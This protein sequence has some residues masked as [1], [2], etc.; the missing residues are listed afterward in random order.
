MCSTFRALK[1][2]E[3]QA[4]LD[5]LEQREYEAGAVIF[6]QGEP[7]DRF[8]L[9]RSGRARVVQD[10]RELG[11]VEVVEEPRAQRLGGDEVELGV[12]PHQAASLLGDRVAV[13]VAE[14][15]EHL[16]DPV[17][18]A[19]DGVGASFDAAGER[20]RLRV[21]C[22]EQVVGE[23][24]GGLRTD[25]GQA[26]ERLDQSGDG[27][28]DDRGHRGLE[29]QPGQA[30]R[31]GAHLLGRQL[32]A[33]ADRVVH[34]RDDQVLEHVDVVTVDDHQPR[35]QAIGITGD[36][37]GIVGENALVLKAAGPKTKVIDAGGALV[38][39]GFIETHGHFLGLGRSKTTLDLSCAK[40]WDEIIA[41]V[42]DAAK[43]AKPV[44]LDVRLKYPYEHS[45]MK[46]PGAIRM[47]PPAHQ[48]VYRLG[49]TP[50]VSG[51]WALSFA[52]GNGTVPDEHEVADELL[53]RMR[54]AVRRRL[55]SK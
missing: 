17:E 28:D 4:I 18:L 46:L 9:V 26:G 55:M 42:A 33:G 43:K 36:R 47:L 13:E 5:C 12:D 32:A 7:G 16:A 30:P 11:R 40:S 2:A 50:A 45:T 23:P 27:L 44:L 34:R 1:P 29:A 52:E 41:I 19:G 10:G 31:Q 20:A 38:L 24:L 3:I 37:I 22:P 53:A 6:Q 51:Y 54:R 49:Q 48:L 14:R 25:P 39:P 15:V 21:G 8:Y 35:A